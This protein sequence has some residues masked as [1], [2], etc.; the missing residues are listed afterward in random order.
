MIELNGKIKQDTTLVR[1]RER[2]ARAMHDD[3]A[4]YL[5]ALSLHTKA[6]SRVSENEE[7]LIHTNEINNLITSSRLNIKHII[8]DLLN[9][10]TNENELLIVK[11]RKLLD[12]WNLAEKRVDQKFEVKG[13]INRL[14]DVIASVSYK[15]IQESI[16]N[17]YRHA[18]A[19]FFKLTLANNGHYLN[20]IVQ[21]NGIGFNEMKTRYSDGVNGM[22]VRLENVGGSLDID[23]KLGSGTS[24]Y[25]KIPLSR[26]TI[27]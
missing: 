19:S 21:D 23:S 22:R 24:L 2:I 1:E 26:D 9:K 17:I 6:I 8:W 3:L 27:Q 16:T 18:N 7:V 14:S 15:V 11:I 12:Y 4:Q 10:D 13:H 25:M 20:V 5:T